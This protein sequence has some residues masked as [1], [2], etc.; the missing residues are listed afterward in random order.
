MYRCAVINVEETFGAENTTSD[1]ET[2]SRAITSHSHLNLARHLDSE[3][4]LLV[5][6]GVVFVHRVLE[7][8]GCL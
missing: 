1:E 2:M 3:I 4:S 6:S 7:T 8:L 5:L